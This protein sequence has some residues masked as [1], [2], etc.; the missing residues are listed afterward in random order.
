MDEDRRTV[1]ESGADDFQAKPCREDELLE[2]I[3]AILN[4]TYEYDEIVETED[5]PP[6]GMA[7][8]GL[9][10]LPRELVEEI[11]NATTSGDKELLDQLIL[12]VRETADS[13]SAHALQELANN[14]DYDAL[15]RLLEA[16]GSPDEAFR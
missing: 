7:A 6:S 5:R 3:R 1:F 10:P 9:G 16:V 2:K 12:K 15:T 8:E 11:R 14:Y 13:E 4:I